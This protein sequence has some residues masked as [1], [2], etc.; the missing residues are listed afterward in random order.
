MYATV[1]IIELKHSRHTNV[2]SRYT[3]FIF[4][5]FKF[6]IV[7][8]YDTSYVNSKS[9]TQCSIFY[10]YYFPLRVDLLFIIS[11]DWSSES[12][13][14]KSESI[15]ENKELYMYHHF[16]ATHV[17]S[18]LFLAFWFLILSVCRREAVI[19]PS[20]GLVVSIVWYDV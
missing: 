20:I 2:H 8:L 6:M 1:L 17:Y 10:K 14:I 19:L 5:M 9:L 12:V 15:E 13:G 3:R 18:G 16:S 11:V 7:V 4:F